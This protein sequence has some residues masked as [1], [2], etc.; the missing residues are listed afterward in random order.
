M[1]GSSNYNKE[2]QQI[3]AELAELYEYENVPTHKSDYGYDQY[4]NI[5]GANDS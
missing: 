3:M 5:H 1:S 4:K 2:T